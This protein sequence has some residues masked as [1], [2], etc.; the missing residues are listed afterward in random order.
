M[1]HVTVALFTERHF[2]VLSSCHSG[3]ALAGALAEVSELSGQVSVL[4]NAVPADVD[5]RVE[6]WD[7][8]AKRGNYPVPLSPLF[9]PLCPW[10]TR[11]SPANSLPGQQVFC[12]PSLQIMV[13]SV[14]SSGVNTVLFSQKALSLYYYQKSLTG[15]RYFS[16]ICHIF[17]C[18]R[19]H[20]PSSSLTR[21]IV[22]FLSILDVSPFPA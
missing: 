15:Y 2:D 7:Q 6:V 22:F 18:S 3:A 9:L 16:G 19:C 10:N 14:Y 17:T 20:R 12:S 13:L 21:P 1:P 8:I 5:L 4:T 11:A